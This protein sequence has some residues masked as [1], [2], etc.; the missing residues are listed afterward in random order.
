M[1]CVGGEFEAGL[2]GVA[3]SLPAMVNNRSRSRLGSHRRA[4]VPA[5]AS[6]WVQASSSQANSTT[7]HQRRF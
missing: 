5:K 4:G 6:I 1:G 7:A 2:P 3:A